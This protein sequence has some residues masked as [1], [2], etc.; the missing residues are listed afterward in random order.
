MHSILL[1]DEILLCV[2]SWEASV[3]GILHA[4]ASVIVFNLKWHLLGLSSYVC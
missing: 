2:G 4:K 3:M 1:E